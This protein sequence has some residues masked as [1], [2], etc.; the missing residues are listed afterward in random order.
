MIVRFLQSL[1]DP[2]FPLEHPEEEYRQLLTVI[3]RSG[4]GAQAYTLLKSGERLAEVPPFFRDRLAELYQACFVQNYIV[5]RETDLLLREFDRNGIAAIP[6]KGT[7]M[8]ERFFGHFAGRGTSDIDLLIKP[9]QMKEAIACVGNAGFSTPLEENPEH[10]HLEWVKK[11]PSMPD[12]LTVEL[13][14]SLAPD[15]TS[16]MRME[17]SWETSE[18]LPGY[19]HAR[20]LG[21]TYTFYSLCLHGA[22]HRMDSLR[23]VLDLYHLLNGQRGKIDLNEVWRQACADG[24]RKRVAAALSIL[25]SLFPE[26]HKRHELPFHPKVRFWKPAYVLNPPDPDGPPPHRALNKQLFMLAAM[27]SWRYR[28][29]YLAH[30]VFPS[31]GLARYSMDEAGPAGSLPAMYYRLYKQRLRKLFGGAQS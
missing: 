23:Y 6:L 28:F 21:T 13:H 1:Y 27:D 19:R 11:I 29:A 9:D 20:I 4:I 5:K 3:E 2:G 15:R 24:T 8:A 7:V 17:A 22:S 30:A 10:Y 25:Y 12:A 26:L 14:W 16:R 31:R 18:R